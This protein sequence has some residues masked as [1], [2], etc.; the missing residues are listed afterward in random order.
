MLSSNPQLR[1]WLALLRAPKLNNTTF[2]KLLEHFPNLEELFN[3][4]EQQLIKAGIAPALTTYLQHPDWTDVE[5]DLRWSEDPQNYILTLNDGDYPPL[6]KQTIGAP[7]VLFVRGSVDKLQ[8]P[9][10]AMVGSRNPTPLGIETAFS[11]AKHLTLSGFTVTSGLALGIDAA[12][13]RGALEGTGATIAVMGTGLDHIYPT[14]HVE[15]AEQILA[16]E[17]A[18]VSEFSPGTKARPENFPRRNRIISG[19]SLGVLVVEAVLQSGSLITARYAV[20]QDRE[21]FAIP[22]SIHN[23]MARGCHALLKQG[24]KLVESI[25]DV[26]EELGALLQAIKPLQKR[27]FPVTTIIEEVSEGA[28][29]S[30]PPIDIKLVKCIGFEPTAIDII[31]ERSGLSAAVVLSRLVLLELEG[32]ITAA[33]GGYILSAQ[34]KRVNA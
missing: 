2:Q 18:L 29:A 27:T 14:R 3:C 8:L 13:H 5:K 25:A 30:L 15:L 16:Q 33:S 6:L 31:V 7:W 12:S 1:Y 23:P 19:L 10:L 22:G 28:T 9:Q 21:I 34:V 32:Y 17:G 24:A 4:S 11:F 20:E 26:L